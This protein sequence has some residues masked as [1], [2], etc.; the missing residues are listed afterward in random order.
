MDDDGDDKGLFCEVIAFGFNFISEKLYHVD[1]ELWLQWKHIPLHSDDLKGV[2]GR[3]L[4]PLDNACRLAIETLE[5]H[6]HDPTNCRSDPP[7]EP[8]P[9]ACKWPCREAI[10]LLLQ[11]EGIPFHCSQAVKGDPGGLSRALLAAFAAGR[12][13]GRL[14]AIGAI[15]NARAGLSQRENRERQR[16]RR[17]DNARKKCETDDPVLETRGR[18]WISD[19]P[20]LG[21]TNTITGLK[22]FLRIGEPRVIRLF[23]DHLPPAGTPP[24]DK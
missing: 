19:N 23:D 12:A 5:N 11:M 22:D 1:P 13:M 2:I 24:A 14:D 15:K 21:R 8:A 10:S 16:Q 6:G 17:S 20:T 18:R 4:P 3:R 9:D 7:K